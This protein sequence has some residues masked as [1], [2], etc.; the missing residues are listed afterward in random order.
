MKIELFEKS[1]NVKLK[2]LFKDRNIHYIRRFE[3]G[4][5]DNWVDAVITAMDVSL[6]YTS[7]FEESEGIF[8]EGDCSI[9][10]KQTFIPLSIVETIGLS[11]AYKSES[12]SCDLIKI[13]L[14]KDLFNYEISVIGICK[15]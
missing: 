10:L 13:K 7:Y 15:E 12:F 11:D 4:D 5:F 9:C 8:E 6:N 1:K 3:Y 2:D 14:M